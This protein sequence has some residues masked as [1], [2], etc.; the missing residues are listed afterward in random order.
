MP[1]A[2]RRALRG[3]ALLGVGLFL[4]GC[5]FAVASPVPDHPRAEV[6][7]GIPPGHMPPPG[8]CRVWYPHEPPGQQPPPGPCD[9]LRADAAHG[10]WLVYRPNKEKRVYRIE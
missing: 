4:Q 10:A 7:R 8:S 5:S 1:V 2:W 9:E 3:V 6:A